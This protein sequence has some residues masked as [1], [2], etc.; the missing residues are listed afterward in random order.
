M[1]RGLTWHEHFINEAQYKSLK[2]KDPSTKVGCI[3]VGPN[4]E[5]L[6]SGFN[7]FAMGVEDDITKVPER[8]E[9]PLKYDYT[10]HAERNCVDLSARSGICLKNATAYLNWEPIP[11]P[12][13]CLGLIQ[14]GISKIIGPDRKFAGKGNWDSLYKVSLPMLKEAGIKLLVIPNFQF[15]VPLELPEL[16]EIAQ[17]FEL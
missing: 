10:N 17:P 2:S 6:I 1:K 9:R 8:Y 7:G 13:C 14:A 11:C 4:N 5:P 15:I 12:N 16:G 3:I